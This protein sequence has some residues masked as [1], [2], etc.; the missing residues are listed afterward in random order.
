ME[1]LRGESLAEALRRRG[2]FP[3]REALELVDE[4]LS[5]LGAAHQAG[6]VHRDLKP[7]NI[8]LVTQSDGE[9]YLKLLDFGLAKQSAAP[10]SETPQT[11][12]GVF[13]GTPEY[14][15]PEQARGAEVGPASDL[16]ALG[17]VLFELLTG[18]LPFVAQT[19][20]EFIL[21]HLEAT[22]P[23]PSSLRPGLPPLVDA[24]V[25]SLLSKEATQRPRSAAEVRATLAALLRDARLDEAAPAQPQGPGLDFTLRLGTR[26][27][28]GL[29]WL[30]PSL[31]TLRAQV[32]ERHLH[33]CFGDSPE[34]VR[35]LRHGELDCA[36]TSARLRG[37]WLRAADLHEEAYVLVGA[38][39]TAL[40]PEQ[41]ALA[42]V[43]A[44][45]PLF[46]YLQDSH[47]PARAWRFVETDVL[48]TIA[49]VRYRLLE[50]GAVAVLPLYFVQRDLDEGKLQVLLPE[51][52]LKRDCF[53]L[54]WRDG[55][56]RAADIERLASAL[57]ALPLT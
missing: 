22:P 15:A 34:L 1:Y 18:R 52:A 43:H 19:P 30:V 3:M 24:L 47:P 14:V 33:L 2:A 42:D 10:S 51:V 23:V 9:S 41:L 57:R 21:Q 45:T 31:R 17:V 38:P 26:F 28:L 56:P 12:H 35:Q 53:R 40:A 11:R 5:A 39:G 50:G 27:E 44:D 6:I 7:S 54:V 4:A 29:S 32:P 16:Y 55:H 20:I 36:V 49:A 48:G 13:V 8:F 46:R 37:D 25:L